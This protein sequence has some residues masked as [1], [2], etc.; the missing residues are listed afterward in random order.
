MLCPN[1]G[2]ENTNAF[3]YCTQCQRPLSTAGGAAVMPSLAG[4]PPRMRSGPKI[5]L[6]L[7]GFV[8]TAAGVY[9]A[10]FANR[11]GISFEQPDQRFARLLREAAGLQPVK[12][13]G[14]GRERQLD[15]AVREQ[16]RRL[17][18]QNR[19]YVAQG[20]QLDISK[21][22]LLNSAKG[23]TDPRAEQEGLAQLHALYAAETTHEDKVRGIISDLRQ[24]LENFASSNS[25]REA[26][27]RGF[28]TSVIAQIARRQQA[29]AT[30][31]AWVDAVEDLHAYT[32][33]HRNAFTE[34]GG[35][36]VFSD[37]AVRR[38]FHAKAQFQ[39]QKRGELL[40]QQRLFAQTQKESLDKMGLTT[41]DING[42]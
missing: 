12:H 30:A 15:D 20:K 1:C 5:A 32:H 41:K 22:K 35:R 40:V 39:D 18:Q 11:G 21:L 23:F 27:T 19:D 34:S 10:F 2:Q 3:G 38:E 13:L 42:K 17:L 26:M 16:Y 25:E 31:K 24:V 6:V 37:P 36:L 4:S 33:A 28:D 8:L 29:L 14:S 9:G 7:L